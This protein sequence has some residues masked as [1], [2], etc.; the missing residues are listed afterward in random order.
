MP[1][2]P[3]AR[4]FFNRRIALVT[5]CNIGT[6]SETI[7]SCRHVATN[8]LHTN[9]KYYSLYTLGAWG[10]TDY[11]ICKTNPKAEMSNN[12]LAVWIDFVQWINECFFFTK[13]SAASWSQNEYIFVLHFSFSVFFRFVS[14]L[15]TLFLPRDCSLWRACTARPLLS[16]GLVKM[17]TS[18]TATNPNGDMATRSKPKRRQSLNQNGDKRILFNLRSNRHEHESEF[19]GKGKSKGLDTCYSAPLTWVRLVTSSALQSRK[20]QL[21]GMSQWCRS[22]LCG[23]PLPALTDNWTHGAASRHTIAPISHTRPSPRSHSYTI[24]S[25]PVPLRV[26]D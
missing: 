12:D 11:K 18:Q 24:Y 15:F 10:N 4:P 17:A 13:D 2:A 25:F 20:W 7:T 3:A 22:A 5:S 14:F 6:S 9:T 26:R 8:K 23:H 19:K 16:C 1:S 21:I